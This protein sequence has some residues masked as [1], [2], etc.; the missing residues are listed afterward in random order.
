MPLMFGMIRVVSAL[1]ILLLF[2]FC[3]VCVF[4]MASVAV[5][6]LVLSVA[7]IGFHLLWSAVSLF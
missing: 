5:L 2:R 4:I 6:L 1:V 7:A 3:S